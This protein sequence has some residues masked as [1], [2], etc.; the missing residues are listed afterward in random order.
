VMVDLEVAGKA[1]R[2][3]GRD[4]LISAHRLEDVAAVRRALRRARLLVR[5]TPLHEKTFQ[6][7]DVCLNAGADLLMLP[8]FHTAA[9][10]ERFQRL[11]DGRAGVV[12]LVETVAAM[13][14]LPQ[15]VRLAGISWIHVG[16]ND[17][18]L[19]MGSEFLF[20]P[21][22]DGT[23]DRIASFCR[24]AGVP[25]GIGGVSRVG[26]GVVP[27]EAVLGEHARLGSTAAILSRS[28]HQCAG[29]VAELE[30]KIDFGAE[31]AKLRQA[32]EQRRRRTPPRIEADR[33]TFCRL[34]DGAVSQ[35]A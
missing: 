2:Q 4:T 19:E 32:F 20:R 21:L 15:V 35:T 7:V 24:A 3:R 34:V 17:L 1:E 9:E 28:F 12:P 27:G 10:V 26:H 25:F 31:V 6:E 30:Q 29:S 33:R 22:A 11:V 8:M 13:R 23:V 18:H 16:L 5:V 14:E